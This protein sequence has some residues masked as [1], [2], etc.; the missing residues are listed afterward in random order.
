MTE[1]RPDITY[2]GY[3]NIADIKRTEGFGYIHIG[4][5]NPIGG[6]ALRLTESPIPKPSP[7]EIPNG[8]WIMADQLEDF[9]AAMVDLKNQYDQAMKTVPTK[10]SD[11][12]L[13]VQLVWRDSVGQLMFATFVQFLGEDW[14]M[15]LFDARGNEIA[16]DEIE[17]GELMRS[18]DKV[19][20]TLAARIKTPIE[21][22]PFFDRAV[23]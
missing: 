6:W 4:V 11:A 9:R 1:F 3:A 23:D 17:Y 13:P 5:G 21:F 22:K 18:L 10:E 20:T 2:K 14:V 16:F 12:L 7:R 19:K 15:L 8:I